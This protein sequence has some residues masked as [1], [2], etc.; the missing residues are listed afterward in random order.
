M[1]F[2]STTSIVITVSI[3]R[4]IPIIATCFL[5]LYIYIQTYSPEIANLRAIVPPLGVGIS[6][7]HG[8][9]A[10]APEHFQ[11]RDLTTTQYGDFPN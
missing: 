9:H 7:R 3:I 8:V 4:I 5:I 2:L 1:K 6:Q 10:K 11:K